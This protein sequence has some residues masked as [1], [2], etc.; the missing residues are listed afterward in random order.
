VYSSS[1]P[2][3]DLDPGNRAVNANI[4]A[5]AGGTAYVK[6]GGCWGLYVEVRHSD[7]YITF[8]A[9]L[10]SAVWPVSSTP[11]PVARGQKLGVEGHSG[12]A[13][14]NHLHF[15]VQRRVQSGST[16]RFIHVNPGNPKSPGSTKC[17]VS[18]PLWTSCPA[19]RP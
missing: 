2:A 18:Q 5:A 4:L 3:W 10:A 14:G 16:V 19:R 1:H 7:G 15:E 12:C 13:Q 8:Y 11:H 9:H 6:R 17:N